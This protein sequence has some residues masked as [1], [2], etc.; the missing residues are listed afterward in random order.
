MTDLT[1][2]QIR[3]KAAKVC[4]WKPMGYDYLLPD[5]LHDLNDA[6]ALADHVCYRP[7]ERWWDW[8]IGTVIG[9]EEKWAQIDDWNNC[10]LERLSKI[11]NAFAD[12]P[13]R[14]LTLAV[15]E[16]METQEPPDA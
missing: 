15:L 10:A 6:V 14:A 13:A 16:A 12:S 9:K 1:D 7:P 3:V 5:P 2:D 8:S 4:G 11:A